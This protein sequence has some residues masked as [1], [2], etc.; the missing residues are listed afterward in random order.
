[1]EF[2]SYAF[3]LFFAALLPSYWLSAHVAAGPERPAA[4]SGL[5]LL[6]VLEPQVPLAACALDGRRLRLRPLARPSG[7]PTSPASRSSPSAWS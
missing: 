6:C 3:A 4:G 2:N 7:E 5:L 1:M